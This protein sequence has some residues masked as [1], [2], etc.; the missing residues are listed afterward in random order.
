MKTTYPSFLVFP[1]PNWLTVRSSI[2]FVFFFR[3]ETG[4]DF[5]RLTLHRVKVAEPWSTLPTH[6]V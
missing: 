4:I 6:D 3:Q 2:Q 5:Q 1:P